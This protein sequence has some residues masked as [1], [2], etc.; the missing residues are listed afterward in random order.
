MPLAFR[1]GDSLAGGEEAVRGADADHVEA[2]PLVTREHVLELVFPQQAVVHE[3]ADELVADGLVYQ[4][5]GDGGVHTAGKAEYDGVAADLGPDFRDGSVDEL[6]GIQF[7]SII[8]SK[9]D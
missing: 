9:K 5:G 8:H 4:Q 7:F 1:I 2:H 3:D 6:P